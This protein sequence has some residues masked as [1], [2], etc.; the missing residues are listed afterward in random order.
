MGYFRFFG[1]GIKKAFQSCIDTIIKRL[2]V[3]YKSIHLLP[4]FYWFEL[5]KNDYSVLYKVKFTKYIPNFFYEIALN[6]MFEFDNLDLTLLRKK[7]ELA[8]LRSISVRTNNK[9]YKFQADVLEKEINK[10]LEKHGKEITMNEFIDYI[11]LTFNTPGM[12]KPFETSTS[13]TFSLYHRA[14]ERNKALQ[15]TY[16]KNK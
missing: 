15:K 4:I 13:R 1:I 3:N 8:V 5:Q 9:S 11:E 6:M 10:K 14:I 12:I 7:G 2:P 16:E